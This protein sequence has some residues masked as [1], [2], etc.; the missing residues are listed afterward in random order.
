TYSRIDPAHPA[1]F[2]PIVIGGMLRHDLGFG[3]VV[4]SDDLANARQVARWSPATRA[5]S[6]IAAGGDVVLV[7]DARPVAAMQRA[8]LARAMADQA[9]RAEVD[10]AALRVLRAKAAAHLLP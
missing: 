4:I 7:V 6:F 8:V 10:A 3:G 2:S 1:A 5:V 9:F